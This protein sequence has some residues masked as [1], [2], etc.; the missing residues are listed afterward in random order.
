MAQVLGTTYITETVYVGLK[1][2]KE[3]WNHLIAYQII[4]ISLHGP[5]L[6]KGWVF[7][8]FFAILVSEWVQL[9]KRFNK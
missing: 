1:K 4:W 3:D 6:S 9:S 7:L 5:Y 8:S 2:K